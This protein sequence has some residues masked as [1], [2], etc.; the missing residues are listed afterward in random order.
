M[1]TAFN[2]TTVALVAATTMMFCLFL[3]ERAERAVI[4]TVDSRT[5]R[6]LLN[7]FE[8]VAANLTPFLSAL[9]AANQA[10]LK[11]VEDAVQQQM[12]LLAD[13]L[14]TWQ[15][16]QTKV[17]VEALEKLEQRFEANDAQREQRSLT[18]L[19]AI[20]GH[21]GD[22]RQQA[23]AVGEQMSLLT[24][25]LAKLAQEL[26]SVFQ[27]NG[28]LVKLQSSLAEN[29]RLLNHTQQFDEALHGLTAAI[30][31]LTARNQPGLRAA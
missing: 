30:H 18:L 15:Q 3:C 25:E 8:V 6:E 17:W 2:T 29:L 9:G 7:R 28:E 22:Q 26:G 13:A 20:E 12:E 24:E 27:G 4:G 16:Q 1:G 10:T 19:E 21:R 11:T 14:Q 23:Q 31:L 5:E